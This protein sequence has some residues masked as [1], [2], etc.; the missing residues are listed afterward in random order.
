ML[1]DTLRGKINSSTAD[2]H[3]HVV[4]AEDDDGSTTDEDNYDE[5]EREM[6]E[7]REAL[8]QRGRE[9]YAKRKEG[10]LSSANT[11]PASTR[12]NRLNNT[13]HDIE[14]DDDGDEEGDIFYNESMNNGGKKP[15]R[16]KRKSGA[17]DLAYR[18]SDDG[19]D[20]EED[21][22][23]HDQKPGSAK[24]RVSSSRRPGGSP[25]VMSAVTPPSKP[26]RQDTTSTANTVVSRFKEGSMRDRASAVPP[27]EI[28]GTLPTSSPARPEDEEVPIGMSTRESGLSNIQSIRSSN[29]T[30]KS[31]E[32]SFTFGGLASL[33]PFNPFKLVKDIKE[34][35]DRQKRLHEARERK[36]KIL[37]DRKKKGQLAYQELK[38]MGV[39]QGYSGNAAAVMGANAITR[40][41][42]S[43]SMRVPSARGNYAPDY[44][45]G[46]TYEQSIGRAYSTDESRPASRSSEQGGNVELRRRRSALVTSFTSDVTMKGVGGG[47][48][49]ERPYRDSGETFET[50]RGR[51][52]E[53]PQ[54]S[55]DFVA[56]PSEPPENFSRKS[57]PKPR[58][59]APPP[60]SRVP[61]PP[62][63]HSS[64]RAVPNGGKFEDVK[65][66]V[67][68]KSKVFTSTFG[69]RTDEGPI[70]ASLKAVGKEGGP[71]KREIKRQERLQ[72]KVSNLEEQLEKARR[73]LESALDTTVNGSVPPLPTLKVSRKEALPRLKTA[74][75]SVLSGEDTEGEETEVDEAPLS[76]VMNGSF[77]GSFMAKTAEMT[78]MESV[79]EAQQ[80]APEPNGKGKA[81]SSGVFG[82]VLPKRASKSNLGAGRRRKVSGSG[83]GPVAGS[84]STSALRPQS[85]S[86]TDMRNVKNS[87]PPPETPTEKV[88]PVPK[89]VVANG[90]RK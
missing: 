71:S 3:S 85:K 64:T 47:F 51:D 27:Q 90:N 72:K 62:P 41:N 7:R 49:T 66:L 38:K 77:G 45:M 14:D 18:P 23:Y 4:M 84:S 69:G 59:F 78:I 22:G 33:M 86:M 56:S 43:G 67:K 54:H 25:G 73:E 34:S 57:T 5:Q 30:A 76:P 79:E 19:S 70:K 58:D 8:R 80:E 35:W 29:G 44:T 13:L 42:S 81:S 31:A 10:S 61:P 20:T 63:P 9:S 68:K 88:P 50:E 2:F 17:G 16:K 12:S 6:Q 39:M 48:A 36:K 83:S 55:S 40:R 11:T 65:T 46:G 82:M 75:E 37:R 53:M 21:E 87:P 74:R 15:P 32:G 89:F 60:P 28:V 24:R 52:Y 26:K 1:R